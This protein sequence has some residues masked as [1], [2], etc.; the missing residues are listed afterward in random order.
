MIIH[1]VAIGQMIQKI[2][3]LIALYDN[4]KLSPSQSRNL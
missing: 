4:P 2:I 1:I 3:T